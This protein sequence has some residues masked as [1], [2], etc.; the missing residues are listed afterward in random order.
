MTRSRWLGLAFGVALLLAAF[1]L[2]V[3]QGIGTVNGA[4]SLVHAAAAPTPTTAPSAV[5]STAPNN[6][7]PAGGQK[8]NQT[9]VDLATAFWNALA[10][11]LGITVDDLKSKAAQA[12]QEAIDQAVKDGKLT[13][14]QGNALK[15][16][17]NP[18]SPTLLPFPGFVKPGFGRGRGN[19]PGTP[20]N[21]ATTPPGLNR[22]F[23]FGVEGAGL[24]NVAQLEALAKVL[25]LSTSDLATQLR[26]GKT[27]ADIATAQKVDQ[28]TVKQTII[29]TAKA[30]VARALQD[31]LITQAQADQFNSRL[32]PDQIDLTKPFGFWGWGHF[33]K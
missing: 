2:A 10:A 24:D 8:S 9:A 30:Q 27:L 15:Q 16:K 31:G 32:T 19:A 28:N 1:G 17:L 4:T 21:G 12:E 3:W 25:N 18:N 6:Q 29:D 13:Q 23:G 20:G 7:A 11:K 22:R 14:D 5:P 33:G 26:S